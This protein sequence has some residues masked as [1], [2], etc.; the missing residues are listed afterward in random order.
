[1]GNTAG[2]VCY[3]KTV[4]HQL[5]TCNHDSILSSTVQ[6]LKRCACLQTMTR[7]EMASSQPACNSEGKN[8]A[9]AKDQP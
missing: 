5:K 8:P 1:L 7:K 9:L 3:K 6:R 4:K 2:V